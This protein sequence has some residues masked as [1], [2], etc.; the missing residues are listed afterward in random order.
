MTETEASIALNMVPN[1][2]PVRMRKLLEVFQTPERILLARRAELRA[3]EGIGEELASAISNWEQ[4]IDLNQELA[5]IEQFGA[6]VITRASPV[7]PRDLLEIY[8]PPILLYVWGTL[9]ERDQRAVG[10]VGS[11]KT[12]HYGLECAKKLSFQLAYA[13]LTV[14]SGLARGIDTAAHQSALAAQGR[15]VAILGSGLMALY[16]TENQALAEK[17]AASGAVVSEYPM[18]FPPSPQTFPY[19]NR[20]VAGWGSG[21]LV[22]EAGLNSGALITANQAIENG[23]LVYAVPGQIDKPTAAGSNRLIQQGAKL[24]TG[25][26]DILEDLQTF[27]PRLE[28]SP[29]RF[30]GSPGSP[31]SAG[32][33]VSETG[34][35]LSKTESVVIELLE[36][37]EID[38]DGIVSKTRLPTSRVS[39]TLLAL[40]MKRLVKKL[41]GQRFVKLSLL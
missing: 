30:P 34:P 19:R 41:P 31:S 25:A 36:E 1:L 32:Q 14:V 40:E 8:N 29:A 3:V 2:G 27:F 11:R 37:G 15:T 5:L 22:V 13:G 28:K 20:I 35:P 26:A 23:R 10:V 39:S 16:P 12:S 24:V 17:I 38:L 7:Y 4:E 21:L 9:M 6:H 33:S 18:T